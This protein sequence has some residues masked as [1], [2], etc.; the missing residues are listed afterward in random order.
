MQRLEL[1]R[2]LYQ[3]F[4]LIEPTAFLADPLAHAQRALMLADTFIAAHTS[5]AASGSDGS[6]ASGQVQIDV[7]VSARL[8]DLTPMPPAA[9]R[10]H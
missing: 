4:M 8:L 5:T 10:V 3:N 7:N 2:G 9:K 6:P 1:A